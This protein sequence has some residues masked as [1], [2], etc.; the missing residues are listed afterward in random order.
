MASSVITFPIPAYQNLPIEPQYYKPS[1]FVITAIALGTF[2]TITTAINHNYVV[3]QLVRILIP[4]R[5]GTIQLNEQSAL[6]VAIPAANQ[7]TLNI[8]SL[9]MDPLVNPGTTTQPQI[10]A[11]GDVNSGQI[12]TNGRILQQPLIPGSFE[13]ISPA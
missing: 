10:L 8:S 5:W 13:N 12:N 1:Q 4:Y 11:I 9:G 7:V 3:G 2:T 6:V